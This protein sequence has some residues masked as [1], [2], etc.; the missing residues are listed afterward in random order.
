MKKKFF[1]SLYWK[2]SAAFLL[3]L[4]ILACAYS[5]IAV[6][7]AE[8]YFQ[9]TN[10]KL[11]AAIAPLIASENKC[12][13]EG[14]VNES[15]LKDVF[16]NVM[17]INPS[18]EI[19]LLDKDGKILT[20]FAPNK[21]V[22]LKYVPL[23]PIKEFIKNEGNKFVLGPDPRSKNR[24]KAFSAARVVQD[25]K[26]MGYVYVILGGKEYEN[27]AN[28][29]LGSYI[30]KLGARSMAI[31]LISAAIIGLIMLGFIT[32]NI[33]RTVTVIREFKNGNQKARIKLKG[34]G[35]LNEFAESFNEMADTIVANIEE[36]KTMDN[37]RRELVANVSHDLRTP[38]AAIQG[39]IET[40]LIRADRLSEEERKKYM[41]TILASTESLKKL[42]EELFELS[43]LE[44]RETKPKPE[45]FS[46][47]E[48]VQDIQQKNLI[49]AESK[50]IEIA[51]QF[52]YDLPLV[53]ADI[54][55]MEK[56]LQNLLD[57][58]IKFTPEN[59]KIVIQLK[60]QNE[61]ILVSVSD[62]GS[63]ITSDELPYIFDRYNQG[64]RTHLKENQGIGLGLAIVKKIMEVHNL[65]IQ[66]ESTE[67]K[68][69]RFYFTVPVFKGKT[70]K[71][72]TVQYS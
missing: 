17:I 44:A 5:Y 40:I 7:T 49:I 14:K 51:L 9:E 41:H 24:E 70:I 53:Y 31:T 1:N 16:H 15:V 47:A 62:T 36:M 63:G 8:M 20:Y 59:G 65:D 43:K 23:G 61:D 2:I 22:F 6:Y 28:F 64:K 25:G 37:L 66:V 56:V 39:Y 11:N 21:T 57:N 52:P 60:L 54:G 3:I 35:E 50:K 48:L 33:R 55:M 30:L 10:Q 12:F 27:I 72:K 4:F 42:V 46:I 32:K 26:L 13:I 67:G 58:A 38:L 71:D 18:I 45:P 29:I 19:Y 34:K 68:G 69:T